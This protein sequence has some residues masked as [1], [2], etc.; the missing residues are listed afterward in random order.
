MLILIDKSSGLHLSNFGTN[1]LYPDGVPMES[2][3][4][5]QIAT[6][7][8]VIET[9][10]IE[11]RLHDENDR[12]KV[13]EVFASATV[14]GMITDGVVTDIVTYKRISATVD[15]TQILADGIDTATIT[16]TVDDAT[17]T[18]TIELY[19]GA[20]LVDSKPCVA[21]SATFLVTMTAP[22]TL[23]L[24]VKSTTK[25]GQRDVTIEGV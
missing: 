9:D 6:E 14:E 17:S 5:S 4:L 19:N 16:A 2:V 25:Y 15:K 13:D 18:E 7:Y 10:I 23:T 11:Y 1:S 20:T 3:N 24:M 22:G 8:G 12:A 21:G